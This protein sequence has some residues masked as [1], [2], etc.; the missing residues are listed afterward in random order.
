MPKA[1]DKNFSYNCSFILPNSEPSFAAS[2]PTS[3]IQELV[4]LMEL[5]V[6]GWV[7]EGFGLGL[8]LGMGMGLGLRLGHY[9][10]GWVRMLWLGLGFWN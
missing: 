1:A 6:W 8:G 2:S 5:Q 4:T 9:G 3:S 7:E 10:W